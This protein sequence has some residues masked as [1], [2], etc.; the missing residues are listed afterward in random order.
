MGLIL[1]FIVPRVGLAFLLVILGVWCA[2]L[3][4]SLVRL[5]RSTDNPRISATRR[6]QYR[7]GVKYGAFGTAIMAVVTVG[8]LLQHVL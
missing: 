4:G 6:H 2:V 3:L 1:L 7:L 5:T 8:T